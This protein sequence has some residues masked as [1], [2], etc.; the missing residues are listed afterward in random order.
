M[1]DDA[2]GSKGGNTI[3][4]ICLYPVISTSSKTGCTAENGSIK[5]VEKRS[6]RRGLS[7]STE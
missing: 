4:P 1:K 6:G 2:R 3:P 7:S 5:K